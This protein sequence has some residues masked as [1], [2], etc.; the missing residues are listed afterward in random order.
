[1]EPTLASERDLPALYLVWPQPA[2]TAPLSTSIPDGYARRPYQ[3]SDRSLL[4]S[5]F[6][7]E[8]WNVD[9]AEWRDYSDRL[10]P[11]GLFILWHTASNQLVGTAGAIHNPRGGRYYFPFGAALGYL[12]VHPDHRG[13]GLGK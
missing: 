13:R 11:N 9:D 5:L 1:M 12:V 6:A 2:L 8:G 7:E 4:S 10:L 3:E